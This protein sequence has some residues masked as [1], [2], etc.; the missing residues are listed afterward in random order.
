MDT[1]TAST[2]PERENTVTVA[3]TTTKAPR[4]KSLVSTRLVTTLDQAERYATIAHR[5]EVA[6]ALAEKDLTAAFITDLSGNV[7]TCRGYLATFV[8]A[9]TDRQVH[10]E[11]E[12]AL[13][14]SLIVALQ[15]VQSGAKRKWARTAS[16]R[17]NCP[18]ASASPNRQASA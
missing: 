11:R 5:P 12:K 6:A 1:E 10:T 7:A 9:T 3:E 14:L 16:Q 4:P 8:Q 13:R 18:S 15:A 17:D 2:V